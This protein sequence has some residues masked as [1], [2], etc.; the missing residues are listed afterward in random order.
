MVIPSIKKNSFNTNDFSS[1]G[2][3]SNFPFLSK[4]IE[5]SIAM[6]LER[7]LLENNLYSQKQSGSRRHHSTETVLIRI[8]NDVCCAL[9][10]GRNAVLVLL[11]LSSVFD[12][13]DHE[14]LLELMQTSFTGKVLKWLRSYLTERQQFVSIDGFQSDPQTVRCG[15]PQGSVLGP[16]L[17]SLYISPFEDIIL[18]HGLSL[19]LYADDTQLYISLKPTQKEETNIRLESC[20]ADLSNWFSA[21]KLVCNTNKS[22]IVYF[23]SKYRD[24]SSSFSILFGSFALHPV[25]LP[26]I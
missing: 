14:I 24:Q 4:I 3:I 5:K 6:Q 2:P 10:D 26:Q 13:V 23:S 18:T 1:Y 21:N 15:V 20:L 25:V 16:L 17:F 8:F 22:N 7:Y 19:L 9:D 11:D 12:T